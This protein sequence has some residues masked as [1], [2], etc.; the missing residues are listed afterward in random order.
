MGMEMDAAEDTARN[1][2]LFPVKAKGEVAVAVGLVAG[3]LG[4][5][6][7]AQADALQGRGPAGRPLLDGVQHA[8]ELVAEEDGDDGGRGLVGPQPV[9]VA[10]A[11][12]GRPQQARAPVHALQDCRQEDQELEVPLGR[13]AGLQQVAALGVLERPVA[14]LAA[15]VDPANGFSWRRGPGCGAAPRGSSSP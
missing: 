13:G 2:N 3:H 11:G 4:Q 7:D 12:D 8:R 14:V 5:L 6:V 1:S 15:A 10:R 9:V